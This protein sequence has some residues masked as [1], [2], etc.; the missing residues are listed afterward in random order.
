MHPISFYIRD[1]TRIVLS[2][3]SAV[4]VTGGVSKLSRSSI[5]VPTLR[6]ENSVQFSHQSCDIVFTVVVTDACR[7][8]VEV[9]G[10][11]ISARDAIS[12]VAVR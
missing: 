6:S 3:L 9:R 8:V 10:V 12:N 7:I 11:L 1:C 4:L 5:S 2:S